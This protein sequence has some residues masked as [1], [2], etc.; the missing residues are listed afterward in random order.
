MTEKQQKKTAEKP[1]ALLITMRDMRRVDFCAEGVELF[2]KRQ[3]L[4][5]Q[6]FLLHGIDSRV[7]LNTGSV[8]ARK[9]VEEAEAAAETTMTRSNT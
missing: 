8:F 5:Y 7:L 1:T 2:F 3:G 6:D 4:D 9:C